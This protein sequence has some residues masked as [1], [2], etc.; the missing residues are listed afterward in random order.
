MIGRSQRR[1]MSV[2]H[3][4]LPLLLAAFLSPTP[5]AA[6]PSAASS[7]RLAVDRHPPVEDPFALEAAPSVCAPSARSVPT[8]EGAGVAA[9]DVVTFAGSR[10]LDPLAGQALRGDVHGADSRGPPAGTR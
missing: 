1:V 4:A 10:V 5:S 9:F 7:P 2:I 8:V 6:I 3:T